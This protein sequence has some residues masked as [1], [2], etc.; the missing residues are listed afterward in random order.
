MSLK[1][2][3]AGIRLI[4]VYRKQT[5]SRLCQISNNQKSVGLILHTTKTPTNL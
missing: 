1:L 2:V 4:K 3:L 5:I